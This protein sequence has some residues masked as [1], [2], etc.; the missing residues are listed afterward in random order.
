M[1]RSRVVQHQLDLLLN[2]RYAT[3]V[4]LSFELFSSNGRQAHAA[5]KKRRASRRCHPFLANEQ[6]LTTNAA[7]AKPPLLVVGKSHRWR[8]L[9]SVSSRYHFSDTL[10]H[11]EVL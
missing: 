11:S 2:R 1:G 5:F 10:R 9:L 6:T 7:P 8:I 3:A 4:L